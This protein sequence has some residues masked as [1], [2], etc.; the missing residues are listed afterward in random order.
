MENNRVN[1]EM[2]ST[3]RISPT[4]GTLVR[5]RASLVFVENGLAILKLKR[6]RLAEELNSLLRQVARRDLAEERLT[7]VYADF[8]VTLAALG[9]AKVRSI[10][11]SVEKTRI[12]VTERTVMNV[13]IPEIKIEESSTAAVQEAGLYRVVGKMKALIVEWLELAEIEVSIERIAHELMLVNRKVNA[14]EKVLIPAYQKQV[15]YV[16]DFLADEELEDFT[17]IKHVKAT[18]R[19][20]N[21]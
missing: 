11:Y 13:V 21:T 7:G 15:K 20:K 9:Y 18:Q 6:D 4:R 14:I 5:L 17:R 16:E 2:A 10:A 19:D 8:K 12:S 1:S 3:G